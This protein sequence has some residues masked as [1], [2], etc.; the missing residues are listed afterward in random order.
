MSY[1]IIGIFS[2]NINLHFL[3]IHPS[4]RRKTSEFQVKCGI[5]RP[6]IAVCTLTRYISGSIISSKNHSLNS[7]IRSPFF[8]FKIF[9]CLIPSPQAIFCKSL[10]T[11]LAI[12]SY[13]CVTSNS[14]INLPCLTF[15]CRFILSHFFSVMISDF[16]TAPDCFNFTS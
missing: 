12:T 10:S 5:V 6:Q 3:I 8:R 13:A 14:A 11:M 9:Y 4:V 2:Q 16:L 15:G 7:R 1:R